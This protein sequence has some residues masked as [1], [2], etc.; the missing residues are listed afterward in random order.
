MGTP[1]ILVTA[2]VALLE[3]CAEDAPQ[4]YRPSVGGGTAEAL[5]EDREALLG[6]ALRAEHV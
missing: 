4:A 6:M 2:A 5:S 1:V 3:I